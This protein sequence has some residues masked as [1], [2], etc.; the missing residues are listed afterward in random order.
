M[1]RQRGFIINPFEFAAAGGVGHRYWRITNVVTTAGSE[2][3][4]VEL[5]LWENGSTR[6]D[7]PSTSI[8]TDSG[9]FFGSLANLI[10]SDLVGARCH[11][12]PWTTG[13]VITWDFGV[14]VTKAVTGHKR[15]DYQ[16][17]YAP[18][19]MDLQYSDDNS[20]WTLYGTASGLSFSTSITAFIAFV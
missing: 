15:V 5:E 13:K 16:S 12:F 17:N 3:A 2:F 19:T 1:R 7:A 11:F 6:A 8:S 14:G 4:E 9:I 20:T 18:S 10:D